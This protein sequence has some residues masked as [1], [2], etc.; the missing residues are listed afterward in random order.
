MIVTGEV[1]GSVHRRSCVWEIWIN[2]IGAKGS[3]GVNWT[4]RLDTCLLPT[5]YFLGLAHVSLWV[6]D[7]FSDWSLFLY[8]PHEFSCWHEI[9]MRQYSVP[10]YPVGTGNSVLTNGLIM[11]PPIECFSWFPVPCDRCTTYLESWVSFR[12]VCLLL[13]VYWF[14][15][16]GWLKSAEFMSLGFALL[17]SFVC[18]IKRCSLFCHGARYI[19]ST[20][21][22]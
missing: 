18:N 4:D 10:F 1:E 2:E 16:E 20:W 6:E 3:L 15:K 11:S 9:H 12:S 19:L 17:I 14:S 22:F 13:G 5:V 8:F 21:L 7:V